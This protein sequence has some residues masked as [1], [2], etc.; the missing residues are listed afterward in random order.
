MKL[1]LII[2][3][4]STIFIY[5]CSYYSITEEE[6]VHQLKDHQNAIEEFQYIPI[7]GIASMFFS[8]RYKSNQ[9]QKILCY[10]SDKKKVYLYPDKNTELEITKKS[11]NDVVKMYFDTAFLVGNKIVGLRSRLIQSMV[12]EVNINDIKGIEIYA[13]FAKT[14]DYKENNKDKKE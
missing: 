4:V 13:E 14:K 5:G 12:R 1:K 2:S 7:G 8:D 3:F 10:N 9:I 11:D 6:L